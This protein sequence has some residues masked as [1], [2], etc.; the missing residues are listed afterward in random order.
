MSPI[1][2]AYLEAMHPELA[3]PGPALEPPA[4]VPVK[5]AAKEYVPKPP[6]QSRAAIWYRRRSEARKA[7]GL[8]S[9][10]TKP[11]YAPYQ[12]RNGATYDRSKYM[13]EWYARKASPKKS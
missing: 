7:A 9:H 1:Y 6:S 4:P 13:K 8:T 5:P 10:G 2:K 3:A 11:V 12:P